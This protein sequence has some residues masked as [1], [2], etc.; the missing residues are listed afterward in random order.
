MVYWF[1]VPMDD[2]KAVLRI[3]F[4]DKKKAIPVPF[5]NSMFI[6]DKEKT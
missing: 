3:N 1:V 2:Y 5:A 6:M 4:V